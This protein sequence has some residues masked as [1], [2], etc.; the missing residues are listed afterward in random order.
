[1]I[2]ELKV[3]SQRSLLRYQQWNWKEN[4]TKER[5]KNANVQLPACKKQL[6]LAMNAPN[7]LW[8]LFKACSYMF[9]IN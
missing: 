7:K 2:N 4:Q 8:N 1:M 9:K 5:L 6:E 3:N